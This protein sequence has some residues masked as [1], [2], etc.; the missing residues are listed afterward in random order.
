MPIIICKALSPLASAFIAR[1][2]VLEHGADS[3]LT[4]K[5]N[6]ATVHEN[7]QQ[8]IAAPAADF[9]PL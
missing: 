6:Q 1:A 7:L 3:L 8:L 2:L 4:V 5:D 9:P